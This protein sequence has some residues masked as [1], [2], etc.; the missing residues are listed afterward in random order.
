[1]PFQDELDANYWGIRRV[2]DGRVRQDKLGW[3]IMMK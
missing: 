1:M 3:T 2:L